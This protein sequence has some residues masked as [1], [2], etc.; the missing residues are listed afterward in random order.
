MA[1]PNDTEVVFV[2]NRNSVA[3]ASRAGKKNIATDNTSAHPAVNHSSKN[4]S[5]V[6]SCAA[7]SAAHTNAMN[8][9]ITNSG[10]C[11]ASSSWFIDCDFAFV[12]GSRPSALVNTA[13]S[14]NG[15]AHQYRSR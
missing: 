6:S 15:A 8:V 5:V 2:R 13:C 12:S 1:D 4:M 11:F 10:A 9:P 14:A 7:A 3:F